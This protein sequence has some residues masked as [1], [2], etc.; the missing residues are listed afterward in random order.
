[1]PTQPRYDG[2]RSLAYF[3][4]VAEGGTADEN[5]MPAKDV[6]DVLSAIANIARRTTLLCMGRPTPN[7]DDF[8][9]V[10]VMVSPPQSGSFLIGVAVG[11]GT[12][13][14]ANLMT[15]HVE[16][17][18]RELPGMP[19]NLIKPNGLSDFQRSLRASLDARERFRNSPASQQAARRIQPGASDDPPEI[20][21]SF[22][23]PGRIERHA[24][25]IAVTSPE[26]AASPP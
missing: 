14:V 19:F 5:L 9:N 15:P 25:R 11:V 26:L 6:E 21:D 16:N 2:F 13:V 24:L 12:N 10:N 7:P 1:M 17:A 8:G 23:K 20:P 3:G 4:L 18:L 22:N